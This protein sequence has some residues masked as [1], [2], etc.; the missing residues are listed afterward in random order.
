MSD[1]APFC[2]AAVVRRAAAS[3]TVPEGYGLR[4]Q[5]VAVADRLWLRTRLGRHC[6]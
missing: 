1:V 5:R 3:A 4:F 6:P 2:L